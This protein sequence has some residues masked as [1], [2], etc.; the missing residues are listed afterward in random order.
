M[1]MAQMVLTVILILIAIVWVGFSVVLIYHLNG[2]SKYKDFEED[3]PATKWDYFSAII[4]PLLIL[5]YMLVE[6]I[7]IWVGHKIYKLI[8]LIKSWRKRK[9]E[10]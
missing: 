10:L 8:M 5:W 9:S 2:L 4:W 6:P 7:K 3:D 1:Q